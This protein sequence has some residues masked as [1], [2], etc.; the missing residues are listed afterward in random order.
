MLN[1]GITVW[2]IIKKN[3]I[4]IKRVIIIKIK[5]IIIVLKKTKISIIKVISVIVKDRQKVNKMAKNLYN[6]Q[7]LIYQELYD[8]FFLNL[9]YYI[10]KF[11]I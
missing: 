11:N 7:I 2:H 3:K 10:N 5:L 9:Y 1:K 8:F 4:I 6:K